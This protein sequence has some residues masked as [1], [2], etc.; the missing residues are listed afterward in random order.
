VSNRETT[1][2]TGVHEVIFPSRLH[3]VAPMETV[4]FF[5][6]FCRPGSGGAEAEINAD[7]ALPHR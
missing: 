7:P 6:E 2:P 4:R 3:R 5:V 1:L